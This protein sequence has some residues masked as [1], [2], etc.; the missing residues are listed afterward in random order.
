MIRQADLASMSQ[1]DTNESLALKILQRRNSSRSEQTVLSVDATTL[2]A[3][4]DEVWSE[5]SC[6]HSF[7]EDQSEADVESQHTSPATKGTAGEKD[8]NL[9]N[10]EGSCQPNH[11]RVLTFF[12]GHLRWAK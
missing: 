6:Q 2:E 11:G 4:E 10:E 8:P 9:V 5:C 7:A 1:P 3:D 12:T